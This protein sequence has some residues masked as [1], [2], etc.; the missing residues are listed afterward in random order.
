MGTALCNHCDTF[1]YH[2]HIVAIIYGDIYG[3][4]HPEYMVTTTQKTFYQSEKQL[5][6]IGVLHTDKGGEAVN[7]F[8]KP[9]ISSRFLTTGFGCHAIR[10]GSQGLEKTVEISRFEESLR[11]IDAQSVYL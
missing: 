5:T 4:V 10:V 3:Y 11:L 7:E 8:L 2:M 6:M 9:A 1:Q